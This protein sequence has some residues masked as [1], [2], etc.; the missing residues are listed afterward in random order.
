MRETG[1]WAEASAEMSHAPARAITRNAIVI[2][3]GFLP[4]LLANLI[5]YQTVGIFLATIMAVSGIGTLVILP[6]LIQIFQKTLFRK[7]LAARS[8]ASA[9]S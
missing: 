3:V 1:S 9:A 2:A 8:A 6:S 7:D 5:P 4:L